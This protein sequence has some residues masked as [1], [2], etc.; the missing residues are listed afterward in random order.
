M[1]RTDIS[2]GGTCIGINGVSTAVI[3]VIP[4]YNGLTPRYRNKRDTQYT[5]YLK[6]HRG[7]QQ[8]CFCGRSEL[9][10]MLSNPKC[11]EPSCPAFTV[12]EIFSAPSLLLLIAPFYPVVR[13]FKYNICAEEL[14]GLAD[15]LL[16]KIYTHTSYRRPVCVF[17]SF[18]LRPAV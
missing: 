7:V 8:Q 11:E 13:F 10:C 18:K 17:S 16:H 9:C 1:F 14:L 4:R 12:F 6:L 3:A 2:S 15:Q 5:K